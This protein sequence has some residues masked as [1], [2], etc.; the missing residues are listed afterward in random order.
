MMIDSWRPL[1]NQQYVSL[2][3]ARSAYCYK[4]PVH[5]PWKTLQND[6]LNPFFK[7]HKSPHSVEEMCRGM[8]QVSMVSP[9]MPSSRN[10][11]HRKERAW[12]R[13]FFRVWRKHLSHQLVF[14]VLVAM[15]VGKCSKT[16]WYQY[17]DFS[18]GIISL[19]TCQMATGDLLDIWT[20]TLYEFLLGWLP[21]G[22]PSLK[23][24]DRAGTNTS[25]RRTYWHIL[26]HWLQPSPPSN[27]HSFGQ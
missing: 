10:Q 12:L 16:Q 14:R 6:P 21:A 15:F 7:K 19:T 5:D 2:K 4:M 22:I 1:E 25:L 17:Q 20:W 13:C 23:S 9:F 27:Q 8:Y 18:L 3:N 11:K 24:H 26:A